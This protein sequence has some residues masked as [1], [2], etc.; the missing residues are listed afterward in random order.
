MN[1]S[2]DLLAALMD[3]RIRLWTPVPIGSEGLGDGVLLPVMGRPIH[4]GVVVVPSW[5]LHIENDCD[6]VLERF[7]AGSP[8]ERRLLGAMPLDGL[9]SET[10]IRWTLVARPFST[11]RDCPGGL[12]P[13]ADARSF[14]PAAAL[15]ALSP[16]LRRRRGSTAP[17]VG[18]GAP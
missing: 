5:M 7:G 15:L 10:P 1:A 11:E 2:R 3:E 18:P 8:W 13:R 17:L 16:G 9:Q 4:V 12:E 14:R 6:S